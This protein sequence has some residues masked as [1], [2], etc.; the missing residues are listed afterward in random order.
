MFFELREYRVKNGQMQEWVRLMEEEIIPYQVSKGMVIVGS[1][2]SPDE[3]DLYVWMRR[4]DSEAERDRLYQAC[5]DCD[6]WRS[7]I[8]PKVGELLD[9][10]RIV[11][12][13]LD[14]T[15]RSVIR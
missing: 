8:S 1:F 4:F 3:P 12:R 13:R 2:T 6:E 9:R 14:P 15:P 11:V 5:Y 10:E 7:G